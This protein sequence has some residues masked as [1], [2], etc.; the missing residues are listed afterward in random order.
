M[1]A[2]A[3]SRAVARMGV[4]SVI[5]VNETDRLVLSPS[6]SRVAHFVAHLDFGQHRASGSHDAL[7][8]LGW[9]CSRPHE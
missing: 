9:L 2:A 4:L 3:K 7:N 6:R 5:T 1:S 8:G